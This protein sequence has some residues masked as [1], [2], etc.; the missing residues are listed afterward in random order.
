MAA[1][2]RK[3]DVLLPLLQVLKSLEPEQRIIILAH[4]DDRT[5]DAIYETITRVLTSDKIPFERRLRL[6]SELADHKDCFRCLVDKKSGKRER[7]KKL[8]QVGGGV[9]T[10]VLKAA[11]PLLLNMF[12]K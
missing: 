1:A 11:I 6:K 7:K 8:A 4:M 2:R 9:M 3:R 10:P 12:E 5:R